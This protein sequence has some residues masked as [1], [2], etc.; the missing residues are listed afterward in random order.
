VDLAD[1]VRQ[2]KPDKAWK[3]VS[4]RGC[5]V[6]GPRSSTL[7]HG[8]PT[9]AHRHHPAAT[10]ARGLAVWQAD[11]SLVAQPHEHLEHLAEPRSEQRRALFD[12]AEQPVL[13]LGHVDRR[14]LKTWM[15]SAISLLRW[16]FARSLLLPAL[17]AA[18]VAGCPLRAQHAALVGRRA[19]RRSGRINRRTPQQQRMRP[20]GTTVV[21]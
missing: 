13:G 3:G 21:G 19:I 20:R 6:N 10:S 2:L 11:P 9:W 18:H 14:L 15:A 7:T 16:R 12:L 8:L 1:A 5:R 4:T 17:I